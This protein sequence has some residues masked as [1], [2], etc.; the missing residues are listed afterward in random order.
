[1]CRGR[2]GARHVGSMGLLFV[3]CMWYDS[4]FNASGVETRI[5]PDRFIIVLDLKFD[6]IRSLAF[7]GEKGQDLR[8]LLR[9]MTVKG[10]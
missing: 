5:W 6:K 1:M 4:G 8:D 2:V 3:L 7:L 9:P 10:A